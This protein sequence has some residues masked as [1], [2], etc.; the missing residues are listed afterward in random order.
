MPGTRGKARVRKSTVK[1]SILRDIIR[2]VVEASEPDK[3]IM[4][5]S[6]ARGEMG[7]NSDVDLLIIEG[8]KF[9]RWRI[10][11]DIYRH[12]SGAHAPVDVMVVTPEEVERYRETHCQVIC[13]ALKEGKI[14]Y[15]A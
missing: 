11:T 5:G 2:R 9:N 13:P 6:A 4:F 12:L 14:V 1:P 10:T 8:G 15:G 7:P 3:I